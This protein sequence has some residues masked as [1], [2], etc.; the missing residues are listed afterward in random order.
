ML[1]L[2]TH[3]SLLNVQDEKYLAGNELY[4]LVPMSPYTGAVAVIQFSCCLSQACV[5]ALSGVANE[6][7]VSS[8]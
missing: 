3:K 1:L 2:L 5:R 4:I 7:V 6:I 8:F